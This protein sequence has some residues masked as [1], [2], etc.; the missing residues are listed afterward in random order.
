MIVA[1]LIE[2]LQ[3]LDPDMKV[4]MSIGGPQDSAYTDHISVEVHDNECVIDGWA[5]SDNPE[6]FFPSND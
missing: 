5:A 1:H 3:K 6:A 4:T 2:E